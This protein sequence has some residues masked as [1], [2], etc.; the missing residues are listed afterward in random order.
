MGDAHLDPAGSSPWPTPLRAVGDLVRRRSWFS[1]FPR[2]PRNWSPPAGW[3]LAGGAVTGG[4]FSVAN[5][6]GYESECTYKGREMLASDM[7]M[8]LLILRLDIGWFLDACVGA[9]T[10]PHRGDIERGGRCRGFRACDFLRRVTRVSIRSGFGMDGPHVVHAHRQC[11][12]SRNSWVAGGGASRPVDGYFAG[13]GSQW[14]LRV[15]CAGDVD[16]RDQFSAVKMVDAQQRLHP[17]VGGTRGAL[18]TR[19]GPIGPHLDET[20]RDGGVRL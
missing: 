4:N 3:D 6:E 14:G 20:G 10:H 7:S 5:G 15:V 13:G 11:S 16:I 17:R 2:W 8:R 1:R 9:Q 18:D 19:Q 12:V